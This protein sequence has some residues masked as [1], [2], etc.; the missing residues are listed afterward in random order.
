MALNRN[1]LRP[2][3]EFITAHNVSAPNR[4]SPSYYNVE[5]VYNMNS[6]SPVGARGPETRRIGSHWNSL[7]INCIPIH[8]LGPLLAEKTVLT[9]AQFARS[10]A[11]SRSRSLFYCGVKYNKC[12]SPI[13]VGRG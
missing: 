7:F 6:T 2:C 9:R 10:R 12:Y 11:Q 8:F 4:E 5:M 13:A 1:T 3:I